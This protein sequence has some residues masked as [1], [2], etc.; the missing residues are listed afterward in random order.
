MRSSHPK[1]NSR[2]LRVAL[3]VGLLLSGILRSAELLVCWG[4]T[5]DIPAVAL[6]EED[7]EPRVLLP[8]G[9]ADGAMMANSLES[10]GMLKVAEMLMPTTSPFPQGATRIAEKCDV[11]QLTVLYDPSSRWRWT[12]LRRRIEEADAA[13]VTRYP[14]ATRYWRTY[15]GGDWLV[16]YQRL[17]DNGTFRLSF[18]T[19]FDDTESSVYYCEQLVTGVFVVGRDDDSKP[20]LELPK[21]N[22]S[23]MKRIPL[24]G[25]S[26]PSEK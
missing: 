4:N 12:R 25:I 1:A 16:N 24:E 7:R 20:L 9:A 19:N 22:R 10:L 8:G 15:L 5:G 26:N 11:R 23:G 14:M 18:F 6:L 17:K 2:F 21:S 3:V 13:L